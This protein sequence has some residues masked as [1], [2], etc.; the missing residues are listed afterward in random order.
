ML[1]GHAVRNMLNVTAGLAGPRRLVIVAV[2]A[3]AA[4]AAAMSVQA[5][6]AS[7]APAF[8]APSTGQAERAVAVAYLEASSTVPGAADR[9]VTPDTTAPPR[10]GAALMASAR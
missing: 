9:P 1:K 10:S 2:L 4:L 3:S 8:W 7:S 5:V 6:A